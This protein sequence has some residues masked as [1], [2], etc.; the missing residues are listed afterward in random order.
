MGK[1]TVGIRTDITFEISDDDD[2]ISNST[3]TNKK[4]KEQDSRSDD[5][6]DSVPIIKG[7]R[8]DQTNR[9]WNSNNVPIFHS[10]NDE[11][12]RH[13]DG[14]DVWANHIPAPAVW[15]TERNYY[16]VHPLPGD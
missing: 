12:I 7:N 16:L 5:D 13:G 15:T 2:S 10:T 4:D 6:D 3:K 11:N 8:N 9:R 14:I 1:K